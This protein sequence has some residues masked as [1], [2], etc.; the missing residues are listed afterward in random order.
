MPQA[1]CDDPVYETSPSG[2][3]SRNLNKPY[4]VFRVWAQDS[5]SQ[6]NKDVSSSSNPEIQQTKDF[7]KMSGS[8]AHSSTGFGK[9]SS[10]NPEK[11]VV[12]VMENM[13][14][15]TLK[16]M[17]IF[18]T[19]FGFASSVLA[20]VLIVLDSNK[21]LPERHTSALDIWS[22]AVGTPCLVVAII[23][24]SNFMRNLIGCH[25]CGAEW[26]KRRR[27]LATI[28]LGI[29]V[30]HALN[31][32]FYIAPSA[33]SLDNPCKWVSAF[34]KVASYL[35][36]TFW[37]TMLLLIVVQVHNGHPWT[38]QHGHEVRRRI[39]PDIIPSILWQVSKSMLWAGP[40]RI[41]TLTAFLRPSRDDVVQP[42]PMPAPVKSGGHPS[43]LLIMDAPLA[44][45]LPKAVIWMLLQIVLTVQLILS[46]TSPGVQQVAGGFD[47]A[48]RQWVCHYRTWQ[49]PVTT[50][51]N[52]FIFTYLVISVRYM[53]GGMQH[54]K[55]QPYASYRLGRLLMQLY[56][57]G[58]VSGIVPFFV[59]AII[60]A[61]IPSRFGCTSSDHNWIDLALE[62]KITELAV[63]LAFLFLPRLPGKSNPVI[64]VGLQVFSWAESQTESRKQQRERYSGGSESLSQEPIFCFERALKLLYFSALAYDIE[65]EDAASLK[66]DLQEPEGLEAHDAKGQQQGLIHEAM[67]L[68]DLTDYRL[69][70]E[71]STDS[72][73]MIAWNKDI[74]LL[75][76]R[77]TASIKAAK[78]DLEG[79]RVCHPPKRGSGW[80]HTRPCVHAG[81]LA[82]WR[83][84]GFSQTL[85]NLIWKEVLQERMPNRQPRILITGHSLGGALATLAAFD[86]AKELR[87]SNI[88]V[89]TFGAPRTGNRAFAREYEL[90]V[91]DT[92]HVINAKD[93]VTHWAKF[94]G[95]YKRCGQR[96]LV[97][98]NGDM[99][100]RPSYL[101]LRA[102]FATAPF[103]T[104]VKDHYLDAY[105]QVFLNVLRTQLGRRGV[106]SG[107]EGC[108]HLAQSVDLKQL[109]PMADSQLTAA[110]TEMLRGGVPRIGSQLGFTQTLSRMQH[111]LSMSGRAQA[112]E[113]NVLEVALPAEEVVVKHPEDQV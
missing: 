100:V 55:H 56:S 53:Y 39:L 113:G 94:A 34:I 10:L 4:S 43:N 24:L 33:Y 11:S 25:I 70:Y 78:L 83:G 101:E 26:S 21:K 89:V 68:F 19:L 103:R 71:P 46:L 15:K 6:L 74:I 111:R 102:H 3:G 41:V 47:C 42:V 98:A 44:I 81:F 14:Q 104:R 88:S 77:G 23:L 76:F 52:L 87:L 109:L 97:S 1:T 75:S 107:V 2:D 5:R 22:L 31:L 65:E 66:E 29:L 62:L 58:N 49:I 40:L 69:V 12:L 84:N 64:Q 110:E 7:T 92:W 54:V 108:L 32:L 63:S 91:P 61:S 86:I 45:H 51:A 93:P 60:A 17:V 85:L 99:I 35:R 36:W 95:F 105:R 82:G 13:S 38:D 67:A 59:F 80:K 79:Y 8:S 28:N 57:H 106:D 27:N 30:C 73:A 112:A 37:N 48:S 18:S 9:G 50:F 16:I 96:V 20:I 90:V 72:K